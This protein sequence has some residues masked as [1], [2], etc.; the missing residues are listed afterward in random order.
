MF[1]WTGRPGAVE[2]KFARRFHHQKRFPLRIHRICRSIHA[3]AVVRISQY[4]RHVWFIHGERVVVG[5]VG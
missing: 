2:I 4:A 3:Y 1:V 5:T